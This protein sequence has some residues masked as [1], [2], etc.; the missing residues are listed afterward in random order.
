MA[1]KYYVYVLVRT[2]IPLHAQAVQAC[3]AALEA[4]FA[5]SAPP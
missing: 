2:D 3:H 4:G 5:F 1:D